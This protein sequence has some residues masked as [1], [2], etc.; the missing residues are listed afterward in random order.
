MINSAINQTLSRTVLTSRTVFFVILML[1]LLGGT[2]IHDFCFAMLIGVI[3]GSYSSVF[4]ASPILIAYEDLRKKKAPASAVRRAVTG[5]GVVRSAGAGRSAEKVREEKPA[6]L[7]AAEP[8][9][10]T[11]DTADSAA[12]RPGNGA[13]PADEEGVRPAEATTKPARKFKK[14]KKQ[15]SRPAGARKSGA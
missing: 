15:S 7:A 6:R 10:S 5:S 3:T 2:V 9:V 11:A 4:V 8:A 12:K 13:P 14:A 1:F